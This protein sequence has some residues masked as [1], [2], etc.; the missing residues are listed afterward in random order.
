MRYCLEFELEK[1]EIPLDYRS[2]LLSYFKNAFSNYSKEVYE[3]L[4]HEENPII[5]PFTFSVFLGKAD[6]MHK[7]INLYDKRLKLNFSTSL[8]EYGIDFFNS[9]LKMKFIWY[10]F[11]SN[12]I[13]L[14]NFNIVKEK[15]ITQN[16]ISVKT[17]SPVII[18]KHDKEKN[19]DKYYSFNEE[20][21]LDCIKENIY[22]ASKE[23]F[24]FD[25]KHD[26]EDIQIKVIETKET[27][28]LYHGHKI[29]GNLGR[30]EVCGK[31]YL[32]DYLV[33]SGIGARRSHGFGMVDFEGEVR[34]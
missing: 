9:M 17:L 33:K 23:F 3:K 2:T 26:V 16:K 12:K 1:N 24:E 34:G 21:Y 31:T 7:T 29:K 6:F 25:I 11:G 8:P 32:L 18:R 27:M 15:T 5:K 4:Y 14:Q 20:G 19:F 30:F 10:P 13:K 28:V 22:N